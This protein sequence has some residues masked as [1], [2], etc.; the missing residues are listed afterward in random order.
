M[1]SVES[2]DG[3]ESNNHGDES[4]EDCS[5]DAPINTAGAVAAVAALVWGLSSVYQKT[6]V[7]TGKLMKAPGKRGQYIERAL[8]ENDPKG[9]FRNLHGRGEEYRGSDGL[10]AAGAV[11]AVAAGA[12]LVWGLST[13]CQSDEATPKAHER[14]SANKRA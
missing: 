9:Y 14:S 7:K 6:E 4:D 1:G 13:V 5:S 8:F 12:A 3:Q 10:K 2:R 11:A